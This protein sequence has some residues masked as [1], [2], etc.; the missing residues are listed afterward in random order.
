MYLYINQKFTQVITINNLEIYRGLLFQGSE[1]ALS[2]ELN[3][4]R[5]VRAAFKKERLSSNSSDPL[6][7][8]WF[9]C[10]AKYREDFFFFLN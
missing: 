8:W 6:F 9:N 1:E 2:V 3:Q 5:F 7:T 4:G 10:Y